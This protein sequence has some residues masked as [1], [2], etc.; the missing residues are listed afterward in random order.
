MLRQ[1]ASGSGSATTTFLVE[2]DNQQSSAKNNKNKEGSRWR[3]SKAVTY[4]L[5]KDAA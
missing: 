3:A 2:I 4:P 1:S 5:S